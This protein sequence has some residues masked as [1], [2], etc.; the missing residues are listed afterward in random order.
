MASLF[1]NTPGRM[2]S[3]Y[4]TGQMSA[5]NPHSQFGFDGE[6]GKYGSLG[7]FTSLLQKIKSPRVYAR[8]MGPGIG[9]EIGFFNQKTPDMLNALSSAFAALDPSNRFG[10]AQSYRSAAIGQAQEMAKRNAGILRS[11]FGS[12]PSLEAGAELSALNAANSEAGQFF[13]QISDPRSM[14]ANFLAQADAYGAGNIFQGLP[15]GMQALGMAYNAPQKP[16]FLDSLAGIG[17]AL[18]GGGAFN[19]LF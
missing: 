11:R 8:G 5:L 14:A 18:A 13:R 17:G 3:P 4:E 16:T 9:Q 10:I 19:G 1:N 2:A 12:Q 15:V 6:F 7:E